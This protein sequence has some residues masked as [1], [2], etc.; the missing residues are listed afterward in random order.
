MD[1]RNQPANERRAP[2]A[3]AERPGRLAMLVAL[4]V[5][6]VAAL[7]GLLLRPFRRRRSSLPGVDPKDLA[8][9]HETG[10]VNPRAV[11]A[12]GVGLV[13][14][15]A[16]IFIAITSLE[17]SLTERHVSVSPLPGVASQ[18]TPQLPP[19]PR[20]EAEPGQEL[21]R[22]RAQQEQLLRT[23]GWVD[24][25]SGVVR[26]PIDRA[27]DLL[28]QRGLPSRPASDGQQFRDR[29]D[30]SPSDASSGRVE[31]PTRR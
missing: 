17:L 19:Q 11:L 27:V 14:V 2:T 3:E 30:S 6:G 18:P 25:P 13:T 31:E 1:E 22:Y 15:L 9:G 23:Y 4:A 5:G 10:D 20:L 12:A 26:I 24:R 21:R 29:A 16:I 8:A 28:A 7:V